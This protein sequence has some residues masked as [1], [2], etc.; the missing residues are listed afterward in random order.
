MFNNKGSFILRLVGILL[1]IGLVIGGSVMAYRV[2]VAHGIA[3]APE[4]AQALSDAVEDGAALPVPG[5]GYGFPYLTNRMRPQFGFL[6]FP[7]IFGF[8]LFL[9]L[10]FGLLRLVFFR[11]WAWHYGP[12]HGRGP[13]DIPTWTREDKE[14]RGEPDAEKEKD[15]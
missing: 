5:R 15:K 10:F 8:F 9:L 11:P 7:S 6:P 13:W 3:Q 12:M 14:G 2:G 1:L 4:V